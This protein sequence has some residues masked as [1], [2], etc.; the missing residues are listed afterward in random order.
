MHRACAECSSQIPQHPAASEGM[1]LG[2]EFGSVP[3]L[4]L[5]CLHRCESIKVES[6]W[7]LLLLSKYYRGIQIMW[8]CFW[9]LAGELWI[10][11]AFVATF[12]GLNC[13][14]M[15]NSSTFFQLGSRFTAMQWCAPA[16]HSHLWAESSPS[17]RCNPKVCLLSWDAF[18]TLK[19]WEGAAGFSGNYGHSYPGPCPIH[20]PRKKAMRR[21]QPWIQQLTTLLRLPPEY[22]TVGPPILKVSPCS[23]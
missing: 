6:A 17:T 23:S 9:W 16:T 2:L 8:Y 4:V 22:S 13:N 3:C 15:I 19:R 10:T 18:H 20:E 14:E 21:P 1:L 7:R 12:P 5:K 11:P